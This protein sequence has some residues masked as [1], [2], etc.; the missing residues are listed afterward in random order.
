MKFIHTAKTAFHG[1]ERNKSRSGLTVLGIVIGITSIILI[2]SIGQGAEDLILGQI[3]G[4]GTRTIAVIPGR[5]PSGPSD[6]A[7]IFSDSLKA[8]DLELLKR[9][10]NVSGL[11]S[12]MP[13]V[14]GSESV[15]F[16]GE[17]Y[18]ATIFGGTELATEIF[19]LA[20]REGVFISDDDVR[21]R[22]DVVVIGA[23]V[24]EELF[25]DSDAIG[26]RVR[27]KDRSLRVVGVLPT[28]GQVSFFNFDEA[29]FMPY[30]T[31]QQFIFGIKYFHR[32]IV[33]AESE[34][35]ILRTV[36][37]LKVTLRESH[38]ITDPDKDDFFVQT[39]ADLASRLSTIT[40]VLT[41]FLASVA[42]IS[43]VVGG[44]GIMN[45]MLVSVTERTREIGLR[46][47][48]GAYR[49]DILYQFLLEAVF[50]TG[51]GGIIGIGLGAVLSFLAGLAISQFVGVEWK[52]S[53]PVS[54]VF[55]GLGVSGFVGLIFGIYPA[56]K[57]AE[58]SPIEALRYE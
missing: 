30:T 35:A 10:E 9:K 8:R 3:Q 51:T 48:V 20:P 19:D 25:G 21:G 11:E 18:R 33:E 12:I 16:E 57:A 37:D 43:L 52:F 15:S 34:G 13:I 1:L 32:F 14:F 4:L 53:F 42:A 17:T 38:G 47:A 46:K 58:K 24:K 56:R 2:M 36:E 6:V 29:A 39:Q 7:Q 40:S 41:L 23:K 31:A 50:L 45:I 28:K 49:K 44:I 22:A 26:K 55:L 54:A 27:V 5:E